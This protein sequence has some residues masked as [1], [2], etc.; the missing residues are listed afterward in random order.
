MVIMPLISGGVLH[1]IARQ[2]GIS[3]PAVLRGGSATRGAAGSYGGHDG[4]Y[5]SGGYGREFEGGSAAGG[6]LGNL[7]NVGSLVKM[8]QAFM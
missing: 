5:G 3:L 2:F 8:A 6:L 1:N 7:G 4:Y